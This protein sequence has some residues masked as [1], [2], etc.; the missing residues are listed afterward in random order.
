M[1]FSPELE[2]AMSTK[3]MDLG[4]AMYEVRSIKELHP[5]TFLVFAYVDFF[6]IYQR[7][8]LKLKNVAFSGSLATL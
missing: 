7:S 2:G 3:K 6:Q 4:I 5:I 1:P 8:S